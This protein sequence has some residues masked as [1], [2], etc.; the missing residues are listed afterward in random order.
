GWLNGENDL[1]VENDVFEAATTITAKIAQK[2]GFW[3]EDGTERLAELT[4]NTGNQDTSFDE[5]WLGAGKKQFF[6]KG[7]KLTVYIDGNK[8]EGFWLNGSCIKIDDP[9][10]W[11][12]MNATV[13]EVTRD[14]NFEV[15][16][17][18]Y[19]NGGTNYQFIGTPTSYDEVSE[20]P[21]GCVAVT[22]TWGADS[23]NSITLYIVDPEGNGIGAADMDGY[24]I[25]AHNSGNNLFGSWQDG[26][27]N[28]TGALSATMTGSTAVTADEITVIVR[29]SDADSQINTTTGNE[30]QQ[31]GNLS[32]LKSGHS[33]V[34]YV[35]AGKVHVQEYVAPAQD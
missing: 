35:E 26:V 12:G 11:G 29:W 28:G 24:Y 14:A 32:G 25:Y 27:I 16:I 31:T 1:D 8:K 23:A 5:Y 18:L 20:I 13:I 17:K 6:E 3:S 21:T 30:G 15:Y 7:T 19:K 10:G 33:Y 4:L 22:I 9:N 34:I 2:D